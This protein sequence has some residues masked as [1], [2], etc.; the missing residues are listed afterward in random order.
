MFIFTPEVF[1]YQ[2]AISISI[3]IYFLKSKWKIRKCHLVSVINNGD[4]YTSGDCTST[5]LYL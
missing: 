4:D 1:M 2:I 5:P 3:R